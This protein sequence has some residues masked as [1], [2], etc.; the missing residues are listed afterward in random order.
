MFLQTVHH[1]ESRVTGKQKSV[2]LRFHSVF[3]NFGRRGCSTSLYPYRPDARM[4]DSRR[5]FLVDR[6]EYTSLWHPWLVHLPRRQHPFKARR[7]QKFCT[8]SDVCVRVTYRAL[9]FLMVSSQAGSPQKGASM[10]HALSRPF[11]KPAQSFT[12]TV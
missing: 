11:K 3:N 12:T 1:Y 7:R 8:E 2:F 5:S 4:V 10:M 9:S 6:M